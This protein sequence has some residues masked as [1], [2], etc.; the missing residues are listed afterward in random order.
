M[1]L[2]IFLGGM[3]TGL[4]L[5]CFEFHRNTKSKKTYGFQKIPDRK[6]YADTKY[7]NSRKEHAADEF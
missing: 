2:L 1:Y 5:A 3:L 4:G 7:L 6:N